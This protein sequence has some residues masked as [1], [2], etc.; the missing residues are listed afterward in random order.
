[1]L[2]N[3]T[4]NLFVN[5]I[6]LGLITGA[7]FYLLH[8]ILVKVFKSVS[9]TYFTSFI[10]TSLASLFILQPFFQVSDE[11]I[12]GY[13]LFWYVAQVVISHQY[14]RKNSN[15][16]PLG[17]L[18][19]S[20]IL[21]LSYPS[22]SNYINEYSA[23]KNT[24]DDDVASVQTEIDASTEVENDTS[25]QTIDEPTTDYKNIIDYAKKHVV[26]IQSYDRVGTGFMF[27]S[28]GDILT[29]AHVVEADGYPY[30]QFENGDEFQ[31][32][33]IGSDSLLD[34]AVIRVDDLQGKS[35]LDIET[36]EL[37]KIGDEVIAIGNPRGLR[38]IG[39][40]GEI[41]DLGVDLG[42]TNGIEMENMISTSTQIAEGSSGGPLL[43]G[44]TGKVIGINTAADLKY[45]EGY[46]IPV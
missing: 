11:V 8:L 21:V 9:F 6:L 45:K 18:I 17:W 2:H 37:P 32:I 44:E 14:I 42:L 1:M 39:T 38:N 19:V 22:V 23:T 31:G 7:V 43:N 29:N 25:E 33:V 30:I 4:L 15:P 20:V 41:L 24:L 36:T 28:N 5:L 16:F 12:L 27:N 10:M 46:S 35:Y 26:W 34:V 3:D 13:S 40:W